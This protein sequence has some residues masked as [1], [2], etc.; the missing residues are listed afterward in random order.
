MR[1]KLIPAACA[2]CFVNPIATASVIS[3][4]KSVGDFLTQAL[5]FLMASPIIAWLQILGVFIVKKSIPIRFKGAIVVFSLAAAL[6]YLRL[7]ILIDLA[8]SSTSAVA[9]LIHPLIFQPL[10]VLPIGAVIALL[11]RR[12]PG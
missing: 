10:W 12:K 3:W 4:D 2:L 5:A 9:L 1:I 7:V 6:D 11:G 8:R